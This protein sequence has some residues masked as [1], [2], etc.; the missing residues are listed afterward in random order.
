M[1]LNVTILQDL[2]SAAMG[3][4]PI[5][6]EALALSGSDR[7]YFRLSHP[8]GT[9]LGVY[10]PH[11]QE[12][13]A[14]LAFT[15]HFQSFDLPVPRILAVADDRRYYLVEDL[16]KEALYQQV[17]NCKGQFSP[18][19]IDLYKKALKHLVHMQV[20]AGQS[21][22]YALCYPVKKFEAQSIHWDLNYF[23]YNFL[24]LTGVPFDEGL[25]QKDFN[26]LTKSLEQAPQDYFMFRDFQSRN[27]LIRDNE[28]Y[29][30]DFQGGMKG[31][32]SYDVASLLY[33][34]KAQIPEQTREELFQ[35]YFDKL[36]EVLAVD[37]KEIRKSYKGFAL[38]RT[39][40]VLGAYGFRGYYE[41]KPHFLE[42][43]PYA[44]KNL[45]QLLHEET[46]P[47]NLPH[48]KDL[49]VRLLHNEQ[50]E[51]IA[52]NKLTVRITSFSYRKGI[53]ADP[54]GNGGGFVFDCRGIE[55][56]GR[57]EKYKQ[58][59]G[60]DQAVIDFLQSKT[61]ADLFLADCISLTTPSIENYL[62]RKFNHISI[63]FGC[64]GGQHRSVYC[65][66]SLAKYILNKYPVHT[67]LWHREQGEMV[68][69]GKEM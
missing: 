62:E 53:P 64:T 20:N 34:A 65:A 52:S 21:L 48:L 11:I 18:Q 35:Y 54:S 59:T 2:F 14:Y 16:G 17:I 66:E 25:L 31:P 13:E 26:T 9:A 33:Q 30:I 15:R 19:V 44:L 69:Y 51:E 36:S 22:D 5:T 55:N 4:N 45:H 37:E 47:L 67:V 42:S 49:A 10:N 29:F 23:K 50:K 60:K 61:R 1:A 28:P 41:K 43:I 38:Q 56:P 57:Q 24:K 32:L 12:N 8:Q 58:L 6:T 40:Q 46:F 7:R 68:E 63:N 39:L 3:S 27:I